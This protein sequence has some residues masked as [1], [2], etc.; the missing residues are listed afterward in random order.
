MKKVMTI[1]IVMLTTSLIISGCSSTPE[2][3][4]EKAGKLIY[5]YH[6]LEA[7]LDNFEDKKLD[8]GLEWDEIEELPEYKKLLKEIET[9]KKADRDF[10]K[11][12]EKKYTDE[13][14][15]DLFEQY[16]DEEKRKYN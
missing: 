6:K 3:D 1:L 7:E 13:F 16:Y 9:A 12:M 11:K 5:K 15:F 10:Y 4:G 8:E 2:S 14:E